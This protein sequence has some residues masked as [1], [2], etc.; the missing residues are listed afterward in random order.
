MEKIEHKSISVNGINMHVAETGEGPAVLFLH[1]FPELWY[2]WRHQMLSFSSSGYRAIAPDLR[3][4][5]DTDAPP[6][7]TNYTALHIIGDLVSLLDSLDLHQIFTFKSLLP[8]DCLDAAGGPH[9]CGF[10]IMEELHKTF[11][12]GL[13]LN[14]IRE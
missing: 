6:S 1:G 11:E 10:F 12:C 14:A 3:G 7:A 2:S 13:K 5:G 9:S 4:Y 8:E